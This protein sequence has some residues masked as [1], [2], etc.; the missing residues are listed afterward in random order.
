[1]RTNLNV[2][3][4]REFTAHQLNDT[5]REHSVSAGTA[6][7]VTELKAMFLRAHNVVHHEKS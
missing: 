7:T 2:N 3:S 5:L 6:L 1:M 4:M